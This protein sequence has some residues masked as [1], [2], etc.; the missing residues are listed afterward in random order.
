MGNELASFVDASSGRPFLYRL[1]WK[2]LRN[3]WTRHHNSHPQP[4]QSIADLLCCSGLVKSGCRTS[5]SFFWECG[6]ILL[7]YRKL[8]I[9]ISLSAP[10]WVGRLSAPSCGEQELGELLLQQLISWLPIRGQDSATSGNRAPGNSF[11]MPS[12]MCGLIYD[13]VWM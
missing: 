8:T 9:K 1:Y 13:K 4:W 6:K 3:T 2:L 5:L 11:F 12:A 10:L 7:Y